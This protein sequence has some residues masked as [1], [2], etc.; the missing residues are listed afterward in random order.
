MLN[1]RVVSVA[2]AS[3]L[4][5]GSAGMALANNHPSAPNGYQQFI[6]GATGTAVTVSDAKQAPGAENPFAIDGSPIGTPV[7]ASHIATPADNSK[8]VAH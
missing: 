1:L 7:D 6:A 3:G 2:L 8:N 5:L 4:V